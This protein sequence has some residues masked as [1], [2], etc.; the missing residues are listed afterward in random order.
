MKHILI[1][2]VITLAMFAN[3]VNIDGKSRNIGIK[4]S[5]IVTI[6]QR[7]VLPFS[8][9][10][11]AGGAFTVHLRQGD[12]ESVEVEIDDNLQQ[13][14]EVKN[15][16]NRLV[17]SNKNNV[18]FNNPTKNNIYISVKNIDTLSISGV[19]TLVPVNSLSGD[20]LTLSINGVVNGEIVVFCNDLNVRINGV[21][22]VEL[23]G[24][25]ERFNA[26]LNGVGNIN[27]MDLAANKVNV[28][29]SGVGNINVYATQELS[30]RNSGVGS[31]KY[32]GNA[33]VEAINSNPV[34]KI[35][36]VKR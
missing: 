20:N 15:V 36:K 31:I 30:M 26:N 10:E 8:G 14:V 2:S 27:A 32:A 5:E 28:R 6:E 11:I 21:A 13:H 3:C 7:T 29:N 24:T 9:I 22:R 33:K 23:S 34:G 19:C 17:L 25:V 12:S 4:G 1:I 35:K 16:G 18:N